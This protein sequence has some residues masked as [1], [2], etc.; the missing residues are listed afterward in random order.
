MWCM[1]RHEMAAWGSV[2]LSSRIEQVWIGV[3]ALLRD[4]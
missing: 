3:T 2:G 4:A 1:T